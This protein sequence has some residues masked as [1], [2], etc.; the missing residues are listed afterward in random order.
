MILQYIAIYFHT[1]AKTERYIF[2]MWMH[3]CFHKNVEFTPHCQNLL[4]YCIRKQNI[5]NADLK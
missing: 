4:K 1:S 5:I 3:V 2:V